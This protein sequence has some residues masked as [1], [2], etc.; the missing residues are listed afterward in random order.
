MTTF[1]SR[2]SSPWAKALARRRRTVIRGDKKSKSADTTSI[3][4]ANGISKDQSSQWQK[5][6]AVPQR[7]CSTHRPDER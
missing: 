6:G 1:Y 7:V 4:A 2:G 3:L 5:L